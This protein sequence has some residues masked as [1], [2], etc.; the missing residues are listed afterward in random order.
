MKSFTLEV[1]VKK[2]NSEIYDT[3]SPF[4]KMLMDLYDKNDKYPKKVITGRNLHHK[5]LRAWSRMDKE[6]I[7][8]SDE[9]LVS[10][11]NVD[12]IRAHFY[13]YKCTKK[14]YHRAAAKAF[15]F[16]RKNLFKDISNTEVLILLD[17]N[18]QILQQ[19]YIDFC[20]SCSEV[21]KGKKPKNFESFIKKGHEAA[22]KKWELLKPIIL[23]NKEKRRIAKIAKRREEHLNAINDKC[24]KCIEFN[25]IHTVKFWRQN[26]VR[27]DCVRYNL[28]YKDLHFMYVEEQN[29]N[30]VDEK[31]SED[32]KKYLDGWHESKIK[33]CEC[34]GCQ[35]SRDRVTIIEYNN[36]SLCSSCIQNI[37]KLEEDTDKYNSE[38]VAF[39]I[40]FLSH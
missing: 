20:A 29:K 9:N 25:E 35:S 13:L 1:E 40:R 27:A 8:N 18:E 19:A 4:Y 24:L 22:K 12:H 6:E 21:R 34:C 33:K 31:L 15:Y 36:H 16:M 5:Y 28:V 7:D 32:L 3:E 14:P 23:E 39:Y 37:Q 30:L 11:T 26:N 2:K 17:T 38:W 10:L